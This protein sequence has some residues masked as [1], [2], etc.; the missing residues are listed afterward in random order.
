M[1]TP[2]FARPLQ[3]GLVLLSSLLLSLPF[4]LCGE[5]T[6]GSFYLRLALLLLD[7]PGFLVFHPGRQEFCCFVTDLALWVSEMGRSWGA[8]RVWTVEKNEIPTPKPCFSP[9][10]VL[11]LY[12]VLPC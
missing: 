8:N 2:T 3:K 7:L 1:P 4:L 10:G 11:A 9:A 12:P 6:R 5:A